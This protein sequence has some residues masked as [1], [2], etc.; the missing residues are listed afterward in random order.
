[1]TAFVNLGYL[2]RCCIPE[3][4]H[5]DILSIFENRLPLKQFFL[6]LN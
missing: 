1:M 5:H 3:V 6:I 4:G 2:R